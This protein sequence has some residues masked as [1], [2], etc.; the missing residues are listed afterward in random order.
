MKEDSLAELH[1][2]TPNERQRLKDLKMVAER[3]ENFHQPVD[4][5]QTHLLTYHYARQLLLLSLSKIPDENDHQLAQR[6]RVNAARLDRKPLDWRHDQV[7]D[8]F[9]PPALK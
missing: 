7:D 6:K 9:R 8:L 1:P 3:V 2:S 5:H 4:Y